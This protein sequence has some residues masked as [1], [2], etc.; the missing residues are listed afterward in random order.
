MRFVLGFVIVMVL[1]G[2][3]EASTLSKIKLERGKGVNVQVGTQVKLVSGAISGTLET[4]TMPL[5]SFDTAVVSWNALTPTGT[6]VT[7]E[8][9][10]RINKRWSRYYPYASWTS[11]ARNSYPSKKDVN[12]RV[13]TDTLELSKRADALQIRV[14]L[15]SKKAGSSPT[16]NGLWAVTSDSETHYTVQNTGQAATS[17]RSA[18]GLELDVPLR[19][20]MIY[21]DGGEVWCSPTSTTMILEYWS[22]KLG[23]DLADTV[24]VAAK[25][26]WDGV[27]AGSGNWPFNTAY[28]GSKGITAHVDRLGNLTE[29]EA[30]I[31]RGVP[32][33]I[34]VGWKAGELP[35]AH[36]VS[37]QGHLVVLRGFTKT[38][39]AIINDP[40]AKTDANVRT[41]YPRA[42]LERAWIEHSGGIVY[43]IEP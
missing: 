28:A 26:V 6:G 35:G 1:A 43:V 21:P 31:K 41:V 40:A 3:T 8:V 10:A 24:P 9:R 2:T 22:A 12:G 36:I 42:A 27:Y 23:R 18:W 33:A 17:D 30:F 5:A 29:A 34:S 7:L 20:Q 39:D 19:S 37:S 32:L 11:A 25:S 14:T 4:A 15:E 13:N 38:G 16:L